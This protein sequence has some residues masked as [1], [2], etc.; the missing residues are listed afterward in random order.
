MKVKVDNVLAVLFIMMLALAYNP[1]IFERVFF[2][3][4]ILSLVGLYCYIRFFK[5]FVVDD[6][7]Y[8]YFMAIFF[9]TIVR[10]FISFFEYTDIYA[11]ARHSSVFYSMLCF[12]LGYIISLRIPGFIL[13][14]PLFVKVLVLFVLPMQRIF[15]I[16]TT[17]FLFMGVNNAKTLLGVLTSL[18][19]I[20]VVY[21]G[22]SPITSIAMLAYVLLFNSYKKF[23]VCSFFI[24]II[25]V[26]FLIINYQDFLDVIFLRMQ[27]AS[28][29]G[30]VEFIYDFDPNLLTRLSLWVYALLIFSD[31]FVF[32]IGYGVEMFDVSKIL[33][34]F[35]DSLKNEYLGYFLGAHNSFL[36]LLTRNGVLWGG[37]F[38]IFVLSI[39]KR[40]YSSAQNAWASTCFYAFVMVVSLLLLNVVLESPIYAGYF[41]FVCGMVSVALREDSEDTI[42]S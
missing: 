27:P 3:N 20:L 40:F 34:S 24:L 29:G 6:K 23:I 16:G 31:N 30:V 38:L 7:I 36:T 25:F 9:I 19:F 37:A 8:Q 28:V 10:Y 21:G 26:L 42:S 11:Y 18:L 39:F 15:A 32:G 1:T 41:W 4:E 12:Y 17:P 13:S 22:G 5:F 33:I 2:F 35:D 14:V